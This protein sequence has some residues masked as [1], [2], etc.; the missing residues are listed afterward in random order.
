VDGITYIGEH[1]IWHGI[2]WKDFTIWHLRFHSGSIGP[3]TWEH[4]GNF[5]VF[6]SFAAAFLA[7]VSYIAS[8]NANELEKGP[9]KKFSAYIHWL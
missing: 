7:V 4:L 9:W 8:A 6:L 3:F 2:S 5:F 1:E